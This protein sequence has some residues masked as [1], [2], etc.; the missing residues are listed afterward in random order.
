M[1]DGQ[2]FEREDISKDIMLAEDGNTSNEQQAQATV[3][4]AKILFN[5]YYGKK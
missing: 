4:I 2:Y 5:M 1:Q 3:A